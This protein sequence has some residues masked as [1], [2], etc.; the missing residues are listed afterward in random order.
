MELVGP[1][2]LP[3]DT[4]LSLVSRWH[5]ATRNLDRQRQTS[6]LAKSRKLW[7][8]TDLTD[9]C[10]KQINKPKRHIIK[11]RQLLSL[12]CLPN[13]VLVPSFNPSISH[14]QFLYDQSIPLPPTN[15]LTHHDLS[16]AANRVATSPSTKRMWY[17]L[18]PSWVQGRKYICSELLL[19]HVNLLAESRL[20][21]KQWRL[22]MLSVSNVCLGKPLR[23]RCWQL[24]LSVTYD[25]I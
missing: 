4:E 9:R 15:N 17:G 22:R 12:S 16:N 19:L 2:Q 23:I 14:D 21:C 6:T 20:R 1:T 24:I 11:G 10:K 3:R 5:T 18:H 8:S 13:L 25:T 7:Y